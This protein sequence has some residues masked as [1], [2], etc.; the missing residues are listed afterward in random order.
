LKERGLWD[1]S[2]VV[3]MSDHGE[4]FG[5]GNV[6]FD[7]HG[8]YDAVTRVALLWH[9]PGV[10]AGRCNAMVETQDIMP[11]LAERCGWALP[12]YE[13]SSRSFCDALKD[14]SVK[15]RDFVAGVEST[16]QASLCWRTDKWKLIVPITHDAAGNPL[17]DIY[18]NVRDPQVLLYDLQND[19]GE[20]YNVVNEYSQVRDELLQKLTQWRSEEVARRGG[21]DPVLDG[22]SLAY[23]EFMERLTGRGLR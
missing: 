4:C 15:G 9:E 8:L 7:H 21:H 16:R 1:K 12:E 6:Y 18:G 3:L 19:P 23:N 10:E 13:L 2:I 17:P 5:E 22:L 14:E 11:T 20:R